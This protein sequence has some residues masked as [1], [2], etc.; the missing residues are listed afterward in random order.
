MKKIGKNCLKSSK[1][2]LKKVKYAR[3]FNKLKRTDF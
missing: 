1:N 3:F 2:T